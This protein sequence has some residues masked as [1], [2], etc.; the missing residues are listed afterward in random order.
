MPKDYRNN[1]RKAMTGKYRAAA[2]KAFCLEC[3]GWQR[4][5]VNKCGSVACPLYLYRP[6]Q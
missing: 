5:E 4:I 3:T 1:Y 2:V 6:Y